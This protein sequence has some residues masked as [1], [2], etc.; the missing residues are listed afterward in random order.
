MKKILFTLLVTGL[1]AGLSYGRGSSWSTPIL[2]ITG[3]STFG[4]VQPGVTASR[5]YTISV[6]KG[7]IGAVRLTPSVFGSIPTDPQWSLAASTCVGAR[8]CIAMLSLNARYGGNYVATIEAV[9]SQG[10]YK[11]TYP[12]ITAHVPGANYSVAATR[13]GSYLIAF[14]V[15]SNGETDLLGATF[16]TFPYPGSAYQGGVTQI[17]ANTCDPRD[18]PTGTS[19]KVTV[20]YVP[21]DE[22]WGAYGYVM[23]E[24]S[25]NTRQQ[26]A[27][28]VVAAP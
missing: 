15:A 7:A 8:T 26:P 3:P 10:G 24:V 9:G 18:I 28:E 13:A 5:T 1:C 11:F 12:S 22:Y 17:I 6:N 23:F 27:L 25:G 21:S 16:L 19:C 2:T 20:Q 14:T 4:T